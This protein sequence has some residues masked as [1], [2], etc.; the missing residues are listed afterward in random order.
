MR[1]G[2]D[3]HTMDIT[4]GGLFV[5]AWTLAQALTKGPQRRFA[6]RGL[7]NAAQ[8]LGAKP[9]GAYAAMFLVEAVGLALAAWLVGVPRF[10]QEVAQF[11]T[12]VTQTVD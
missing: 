12:V 3:V 1:T 2:D 6:N 8:A 5:G 10:C 11:S 4:Q 9:V 7:P